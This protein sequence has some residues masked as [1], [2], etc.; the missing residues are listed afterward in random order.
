MFAEGTTDNTTCLV[1]IDASVI[2]LQFI[3]IISIFKK[4]GYFVY[5]EA[6]IPQP[7]R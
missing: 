3:N 4:I 7:L 2:T 6:E 1:G 5:H